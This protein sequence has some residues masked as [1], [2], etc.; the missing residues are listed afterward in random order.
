MSQ[1]Y[2][3]VAAASASTNNDD[4]ETFPSLVNAS[5]L[6]DNFSRCKILCAAW[7]LPI[8]N[9]DAIEEFSKERIPGAQFFDLDGIA[10]KSTD[11]PH[12]LPSESQFSAAA[13]T[14]GISNE[15]IIIVYDHLG[16][17]SA[18]RAW[19][20]WHVFGHKKV[21]VLDGGLPAWKAAGGDVE[22]T[23]IIG[24]YRSRSITF[25]ATS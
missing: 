20:T 16:L 3:I 13:D 7:Y 6:K 11:L 24:S 8:Q 21:A 18:P 5:W 23:N 1:S 10:D 22:T 19:W 12:M 17:F 9:R 2:P 25:S 4:Q 14:L 15:D